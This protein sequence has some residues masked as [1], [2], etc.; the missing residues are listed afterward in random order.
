MLNKLTNKQLILISLFDLLLSAGVILL[1]AFNCINQTVFTIVL[2]ILIMIFTTATSAIMQRKMLAKMEMKK[3]GKTH[4][5]DKEI[6]LENTI[7]DFKLNYG[8]VSLYLED[9]VLYS[10]IIVTDSNTFFSEQQQKAEYKIKQKYD[11]S[12][13]F[14][15]FINPNSNLTTKISI[16]NYQ[17]KNFYVGSFIVDNFNKC[18]FQSDNVKPNEEYQVL[19]DRFI[20]LLNLKDN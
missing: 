5:Y 10:L 20:E 19:Y 8:T 18:L 11:K 9:K 7:K 3:R 2:F 1:Y 4:Y 13:Q 12:V 15:M 6:L 14:Y 17:A 16:F